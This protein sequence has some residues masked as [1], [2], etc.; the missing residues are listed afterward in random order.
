[1]SYTPTKPLGAWFLIVFCAIRATGDCASTST[2]PG[3]QPTSSPAIDAKV[4]ALL[5]RVDATIGRTGSFHFVL[6]TKI[7][8]SGSG[9]K[10][11]IESVCRVCLERPNRLAIRQEKGIQ[12]CTI[13]CDGQK[14]YTYQPVLRRYTVDDAPNDIADAG[15]SLPFLFQ[16]LRPFLVCLFKK[17]PS[18]EMLEGVTRARYVGREKLDGD[19]LHRLSFEQKLFDWQVWVTEG[20]QV[21]VRQMQ[22]D[23][24]KQM[25]RMAKGKSPSPTKL[26]RM[27]MTQVFKDW[28]LDVECPPDAFKFEP[29]EGAEKVESLFGDLP[30]HVKVPHP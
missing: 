2:S 14:L 21:L 7:T 19:E 25:T 15:E 3:S 5:G 13:V 30:D 29:P 16:N 22:A 20:Q 11:S 17:Q 24:T 28:Q 4:R 9:K 8:V 26:I 27:T 10:S 1:M 6:E 23:M 12:A 18:H